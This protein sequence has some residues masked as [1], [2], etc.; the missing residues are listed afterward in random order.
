MNKFVALYESAIQRYT[1]GGFLTGD[2]VKFVDGAFKDEF[3]KKQSPNYVEKAK[4]F[5]DSDLNLRVSAI[6]AVRPTIHSGDVQNEAED[7]LIDLTQEVAPGMY[8]EF[9]TIPAR[10]LRPINTYPD[11]APVPG[12]LKRD[13]KSN[14]DPKLI[15]H[16]EEENL[17]LSPYRQTTTSDLGNGKDSKGDR[18]LNNTN[19]QIPSSPAVG[20]KSPAVENGTAIYLPKG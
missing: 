17:M 11:L 18:T 8:I 19:T 20:V 6:K 13:N 9:I 5:N 10:L 14:I 1:R 7:F 2:L 3:F 12:S 16:E 4:S 15:K